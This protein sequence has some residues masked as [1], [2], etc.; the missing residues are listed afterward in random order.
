MFQRKIQ[1][2]KATAPSNIQN[3]VLKE[4]TAQLTGGPTCI[5]QKSV[6]TGHLPENWANANVALVFKKSDKHLAEN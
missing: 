3:Q 6:Y 4:C 1:T 2:T 5:L